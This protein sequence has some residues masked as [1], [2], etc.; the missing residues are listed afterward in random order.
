VAIYAF[1]MNHQWRF[2]LTKNRRYSLAPQSIKVLENLKEPVKAYAF[3]KEGEPS[4]EA[5]KGL[6]D[7]Y[8]YH[9]KRFNWEFLDPD[10]FT[11]QTQ[12]FNV[13]T[14]DTIVLE[15][16]DRFEKVVVPEEE[17]VTNALVK[18]TREKKRV[19]Y[20]LQG[21]GEHGLENSQKDGYADVKKALEEENYV[22][23][24]L[25]L[26]GEEGVPE[27]ADVVL[28]G[29]PT[30]ALQEVELDSIR[31]YLDH[32]GKLLVLVDPEGAPNMDD[33]LKTFG[34]E[35]GKDFIVDRGSRIL[36]GDYL[37]PIIARY[38]HHPIT[39]D[40]LQRPLLS[41]LPLARSVRPLEELPKGVS[42][43]ILAW[44][45]EGS[46]AER[47]VERL[48]QGE[49]QLNADEDLKGPVPVAAVVTIPVGGSKEQ[50]NI[51]VFG[52]S[53]F[54]TNANIDPNRSGNQDL[55]LNTVD[56]LAAQEDLISIR[57][58]PAASRPVH[59]APSKQ[60]LIFSLVVVGFPLGILLLGLGILWRKRWK[61]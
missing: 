30:K 41:Y 19:I 25:I 57:P 40:F 1:A 18:L 36:V 2:D 53:D 26:V 12:R 35:L 14:Y 37:V 39:Q 16:G 60:I 45:G 29:G 21:H 22:V 43:D 23:K 34:V 58:K 4:R 11:L 44:T 49:A 31:V 27:D 54:I 38:A 52:D 56:W 59:L 61:K 6:L 7:L 42:V 48:K 9:S 3:Y 33:F 24:P 8:Q 47:D 20:F 13:N 10:R 15:L 55:F 46:W 28:I 32:G 17:R 5:A 51:V 50:A